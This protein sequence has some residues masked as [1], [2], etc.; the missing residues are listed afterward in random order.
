MPAPGDLNWDDELNQNQIIDD[1][2]GAARDQNNRAIW[3]LAVTDGGVLQVDYA[4]GRVEVGG[5]VFEIA[6]GNKTATDDASSRSVNWLYVDSSGVVQINQTEPT[7]VYVPLA[8]IDVS[9]NDIDRIGELGQE[10]SSLLADET[11]AEINKIIDTT[12]SIVDVFLYDTSLDSDGGAWRERTEHTSWYNETLDTATRGSTRKFPAIALIVA[13][14]DVVTIYDATDVQLPMWMVF[15]QDTITFIERTASTPSSVEMVNGDLVVG[16]HAGTY[17]IV[18]ISFL[19]DAGYKYSDTN[20]YIHVGKGIVDRNVVSNTLISLSTTTV[21]VEATV[22]GVD[23]TILPNAPIDQA[24]GLPIP[25]IAVATDGGASIVKDDGNIWDSTTTNAINRVALNNADLIYGNSANNNM[26][27]LAIDDITGDGFGGRAYYDTSIPAI[28]VGNTD[29]LSIANNTINRGS[30][31]GL[32][33]LHEDQATQANG[34]VNYITK[35]YQSGWMQNDIR[36]AFLAN[37]KT[38]DR[39]VKGATLVENG[40]VTESAVATGAELKAYSGWSASNFLEEAY[41]ADLDFST[42]DFYIMGWVKNIGADEVILDRAETSAGRSRVFLGTDASGYLRLYTEDSAGSATSYV[43]T[44]LPQLSTISNWLFVVGIRLSSGTAILYITDISES[45]AGTVRDVDPSATSPILRIGVN[46]NNLKPISSGSTALFRMGAGTPTAEQIKHIYE[47]EKHLFQ[48]NAACTLSGTSDAVA[49][50]AHDGLLYVG[51]GDGVSVF[52]GLQRVDYIDTAGIPTSDVVNSLS[53]SGGAYMIGNAAE[54]VG[55]IPAANLREEITRQETAGEVLEIHWGV[56]DTSETDF[57]MPAGY[58]PKF[59]YEA[60]LIVK[61][62]SGEDYTVTF[63]GF[64]YTVVFGA[65]PAAVNLGFM[66]VR[67]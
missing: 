6:A 32:T 12:A 25:T 53:A 37:S 27:V 42:G 13:E 49:A 22:N 50:L 4:A 48:E 62:G 24:T 46:W 26:R 59:V 40:T 35:D 16:L 65:A 23:M 57:V 41:S 17:G 18:L 47:T 66:I 3:G 28:L 15:N 51:T 20:Y 44:N 55:Y 10:L 58:K 30:A 36:R 39:S 2:I 1:V 8:I 56:G 34:M 64:L 52:S 67:V 9:S 63:D 43:A 5:T 45:I 29:A 21:L 14:D 7:G 31:N 11:L 60:G 33:L 19:K 38:A 54:A 61:E